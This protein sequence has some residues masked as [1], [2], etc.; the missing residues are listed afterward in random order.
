[1]CL[2]EGLAAIEADAGA[3]E[4]E[5]ILGAEQ[6]AAGGGKAARDARAIGH[7][8]ELRQ[9]GRVHRMVGFIG[10]GEVGHQEIGARL[11]HDGGDGAPFGV[12]QTQTVHAGVE[13]D[14]ERV[15]GKGF[16]MAGDLLHRV[17]HRGEVEVVD[18][19]GIASHM[20]AE[21]ADLRAG[22]ED[23]AQSCAFFGNG[24]EEAPRACA[25]QRRGDAVDPEAIGIGLDDGGGLRAGG[26]EAV[27]RAPIGGDGVEVEGEGCCGHGPGVFGRGGGAVKGILVAGL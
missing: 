9:L 5:M 8:M 12:F 27:Q 25:G 17:E 26:G 13:L 21:N 20:A 7:A 15:A 10:A 11:Q 2:G 6:D 4:I 14:A 1:M 16:E 18:H 19:L 3:G 24:G 22:A 23:L